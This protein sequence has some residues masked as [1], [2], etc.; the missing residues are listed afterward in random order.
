MPN[1]APLYT[2]PVVAAWCNSP[3]GG[4]QVDAPNPTDD[5][6]HTPQASSLSLLKSLHV[7]KYIHKESLDNMAT[8]SSLAVV[9]S[10]IQLSESQFDKETLI[11]VL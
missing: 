11:S 6:S 7:A 3:T 1:H 8:A 4:C 5:L 9:Q 10:K 2:L